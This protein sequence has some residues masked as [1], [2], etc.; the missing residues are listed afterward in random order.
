MKALV[1]FALIGSVILV[2][3]VSAGGLVLYQRATT[4]PESPATTV[5]LNATG[6]TYV[7]QC[8]PTAKLGGA[9]TLRV[10]NDLSEFNCSEHILIQFDL[11]SLP[12]NAL[13][14]SATLE[15][16]RNAS[17][18]G[19]GTRAINIGR[20][21]KAWAYDTVTWNSN[22]GILA[23]SLQFGVGTGAEWR[24]Y[25]VTDI[26]RR[27]VEDGAPNHGFIITEESTGTWERVYDSFNG[28][29]WP[30]LEIT[31][32][33][34]TP[35]PTR[36]PTRTPTPVPPCM[37][38]QEP[39]N[40]FAQAFSINP[41]VEYL[42]CIPTPSDFDYFRFNVNPNTAIRVDLFGLPANYDL[43]L[44]APDQTQFALSTNG[45]NTPETV[46]YTNGTYSGPFY[47]RVQSGGGIDP[48][49]PYHLK[50]TLTAVTATPT[51]TP[52]TTPTPTATPTLAGPPISVCLEP[53]A[54]AMI[55]ESDPNGT[56]GDQSYLSVG[57]SDQEFLLRQRSLVKFDLAGLGLPADATIVSARF[58]AYV[59]GAGGGENAPLDLYNVYGDWQENTVT[60]NNR[61]LAAA[62]QAQTAVGLATD[63]YVG[64]EGNGFTDLANAWYRQ[65]LPNYGLM[66]LL[67]SEAGAYTRRTFCSRETPLGPRLTIRYTT[68]DPN[69]RDVPCTPLDGDYRPPEVQ[70]SHT[71]D[72]ASSRTP[73]RITAHAQDAQGLKRI[74][75][76][77]DDKRVRAC[78]GLGVRDVTCVFQRTVPAGL[79]RYYAV[80]YDLASNGSTTPVTEV[81]VVDEG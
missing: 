8:D 69:A 62:L 73:L 47:A 80:A 79:H 39:N 13:V 44:Y 4:T 20:A 1:Q 26:V 36:T 51:H 68:K 74:D 67:Q 18:L 27:W 17:F 75:I 76:F 46:E 11:D 54:D 22:V 23:P 43:Y 70:A 56:Y 42:G 9:N 53:A 55:S 28:G 72:P 40:T 64:W 35:T 3:G 78:L 71:P 14:S 12:A 49:N 24:S 65:A 29:Y 59:F 31:Y 33:L 48:F 15:L 34:P 37:D 77:F 81:R 6:D 19:A 41:G 7:D 25:T 10:G 66:L 38:A 45:G 61:P 58:E 2:L 5:T 32:N 63:R 60:W 30:Q 21:N 50:L 52:K 57:Y 16:H